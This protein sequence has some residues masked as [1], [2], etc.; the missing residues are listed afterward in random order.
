MASGNT[1]LSLTT[2]GIKQLLSAISAFTGNANE[3]V[4]T[5]GSG[6]IDSSLLPPG[7]G[8]VTVTAT[9]VGTLA[10][11]DFVELFDNAAVLSVR[12][13][14]DALGIP[15]NGFVLA[16]IPDTTT[17]TVYLSGSNTAVSGLTPGDKYFLGPTGTIDQ[18]PDPATN[19]SI[20]QLIGTAVSATEI[21]FARPDDWCLINV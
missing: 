19:G 6:L 10:A 5:D 2:G 7:T 8:P 11:G 16:A 15:A 9:A 13:A 17:G 3:I 14:D 20:V 18:T 21:N 1:F 4:A 12:K